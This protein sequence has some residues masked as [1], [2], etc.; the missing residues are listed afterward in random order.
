MDISGSYAIQIN[1]NIGAGL[2][3]LG[4]GYSIMFSNAP[5]YKNLEGW[6]AILGASWGEVKSIGC[7]LLFMDGYIGYAFNSPKFGFIEL[8]GE[9]GYTETL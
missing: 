9:I 7:D 8:H 6:G 4:A 3:T 1:W 2:P 5:S